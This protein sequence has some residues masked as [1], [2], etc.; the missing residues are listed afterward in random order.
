[1]F[2]FASL[3]VDSFTGSRAINLYLRVRIW[4]YIRANLFFC[5][6]DP[7]NITANI[8]W[9]HCILKNGLYDLLLNG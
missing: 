1:M 4:I 9:V 8:L 5:F 6:E 3:E 2:A 7:F